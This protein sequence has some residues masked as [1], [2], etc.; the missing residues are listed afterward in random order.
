[1][2][3]EGE[4]GMKNMIKRV[5]GY[6]FLV[7]SLIVLI[8]LIG[9]KVSTDL[10][11]P[12]KETVMLLCTMTFFAVVGTMILASTAPKKESRVSMMNSIMIVVFMAY[13]VTLIKV[14]FIDRTDLSTTNYLYHKEMRTM[15]LV[16][17]ET[18]KLFIRSWDHRYLSKG[19]IIS[20]IIGN[21]V[22]F[23]PMVVLLW[24]IC[25]RLRNIGMIFVNLGIIIF[26]EIL[27]YI[28]GCGSCDIDD[29]IL[30]MTGVIIAFVVVK[31]K[32][33]SKVCRKLYIME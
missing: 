25:K 1:M 12:Y 27:Q 16:P 32:V 2:S 6:S 15:N 10:Y 5:I 8:I 22:I 30:N 28:T 20:N 11:I 17:F 33:L 29:V 21:I 7:I 19:L 3:C 14:L 4:N 26:V 31:T 13:L 23:M 18:I 24:C 9:D